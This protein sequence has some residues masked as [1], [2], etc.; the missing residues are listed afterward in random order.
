MPI[1]WQR[2]GQP[3]ARSLLPRS[4]LDQRRGRP[5][6]SIAC[7][8][9]QPRTGTGRRLARAPRHSSAA[10]RR[11]RRR[12]YARASRGGRDPARPAIHRASGASDRPRKRWPP[13]GRIGGHWSRASD[14]ARSSHRSVGSPGPCLCS[15][16]EHILA[17]PRRES[18]CVAPVTQ[19]RQLACRPSIPPSGCR[20]EGRRSTTSTRRACRC[21]ARANARSWLRLWSRFGLGLPRAVA[22]CGHSAR[23]TLL[24]AGSHSVGC[25]AQEDCSCGYQG[26]SRAGPQVRQRPPRRSRSPPKPMAPGPARPPARAPGPAGTA[27]P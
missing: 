7:P 21:G 2:F 9:M 1:R 14:V 17:S 15:G 26:S 22:T 13:M 19:I 27:G 10:A 4:R 24:D 3:F 5:R 6:A 16:R 11:Q 12:C 8:A 18:E 20:A 25:S 23:D